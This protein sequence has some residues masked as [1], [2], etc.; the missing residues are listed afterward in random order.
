MI[1]NLVTHLSN[2]SILLDYFDRHGGER[3]RWVIRE[4]EEG[5][6]KLLKALKEKFDETR[7]R[8][9]RPGD[10]DEAGA[11]LPG[12]LP[13][14]S[15]PARAEGGDPGSGEGAVRRPRA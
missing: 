15:G 5:N 10:R 2:L 9:V 4:F 11:A 12:S 3:N 7:T 13:G 8:D 6:A 1:E 14:R